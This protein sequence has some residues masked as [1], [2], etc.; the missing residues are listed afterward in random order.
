MR[1]IELLFVNAKTVDGGEKKGLYR[2]ELLLS[3]QTMVFGSESEKMRD[4]WVL[5]IQHLNAELMNNHLGATL[6][7]R[8][9]RATMYM[10]LK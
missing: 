9:T 4:Q 6:K 10:V 3:S 5:A 2:F 1:N 7:N 8:Q